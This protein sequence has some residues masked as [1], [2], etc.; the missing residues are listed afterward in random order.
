VARRFVAEPAPTQVTPNPSLDLTRCGM[1]CMP[2]AHLHPS[3][4]RR[5]GSSSGWRDP[6][7]LA[8]PQVVQRFAGPSG[9][10]AD[11]AIPITH[12]RSGRRRDMWNTRKISMVCPRT[13]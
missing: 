12:Q 8:G 9:Q 6:P 2:L 3:F 7:G 5:T 11:I 4:M 10:R 13:R 1:P